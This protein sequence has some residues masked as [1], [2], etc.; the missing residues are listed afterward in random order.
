MTHNEPSSDARLRALD[1][2]SPC[3][4]RLHTLRQHLFDELA[5][6]E[7]AAM[8]AHVETC[9]ACAHRVTA[10]REQAAAFVQ[11][12][13][14]ARE[15]AAVL[16][17]HAKD[18]SRYAPF[19]EGR[20]AWVAVTLVL[21]LGAP[22]GITY[23]Q[24]RTT[25]GSE[26]P[27][28]SHAHRVKGSPGLE[29]Y[30]DRPKGPMKARSGAR[31]REGDR[32]QFLY[33]ATGYEYLFLISIDARGV[34]SPLYPEHPGDSIAIDP[35]RRR[36]LEGSIILDDSIGA[37]KFIGFFSHQPLS[38]QVLE[39]KLQNALRKTTSPNPKPEPLSA[40]DGL[41]SPDEGVEEAS[42]LI[43]KEQQE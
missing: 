39:K 31:L 2:A 8:R 18:R 15:S 24:G 25:S 38:F 6:D 21:L 36:T 14:F 43:M 27:T 29:M 4:V 19:F 17:R 9:S 1:P 42:I 7:T 35:S 11:E 37:E 33:Q 40:L 12:T 20:L 26:I 13:D 5:P 3:G 23:Y 16:A 32:V 22:I 41:F 30:I 28:G 10:F 34:V